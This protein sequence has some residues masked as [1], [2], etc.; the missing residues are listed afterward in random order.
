[1]RRDTVELVKKAVREKRMAYI[2]VNNR[3]EGN[4]PLMIKSLRNVLRTAESRALVVSVLICSDS[5]K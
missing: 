3:S 5:W 1:M 4:A 2:L